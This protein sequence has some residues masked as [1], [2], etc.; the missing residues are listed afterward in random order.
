MDPLAFILI[1]FIDNRNGGGP[2]GIRFDDEAACWAAAD[3]IFPNGYVSD[4]QID[5]REDYAVCVPAASE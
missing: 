3:R 5:T 4:G 2:D 1:L